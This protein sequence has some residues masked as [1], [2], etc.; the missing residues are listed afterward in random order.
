MLATAKTFALIGIDAHDVRV[1]VD[2]SNGGL[3]A[4]SLVGL[5]DAAVRES[6]ERVRSALINS[7]FKFPN[8]RITAN[9]AP[10]N[11]RKA[12]PGYDLAIA[13]ALLGGSG[14]LPD[15]ATDALRRTALAGELALNGRVRR[16]PGVLPMAERARVQGMERLVVPAEVAGEAALANLGLHRVKGES[17]RPPLRI[18]PVEHLDQLRTLGT[19][20]EP[21]PA[22]APSL[23]ELST[24]ANGFADLSELQGQSALRRALEIAAAGGHSLAV[25]GPPGAGKTM[26]AIRLPSI[27]PPLSPRES[28]EAMRVQ[29]AAGHEPTLSQA[30]RRP[31]RSPHHTIS[32]VGLVGGGNPP[33]PGEVTLAHRG[34]LFLDEFGEFSRSAL[35]ALRQPLEDG[36]VTIVRAGYAIELPCRFMLVAAAN[37]CPCGVGIESNRCKCSPLQARRYRAR[38]SGALADRVDI[39]VRIEQPDH[40]EL[41]SRQ[42][43]V[44]SA[45]V[46]ERVNGARERQAAR[47]G[48]GRTNAEMTPSET[49][50]HARLEPE[51][52][53]ALAEH[54]ATARLSGRGHERVLRLARTIADLDGRE[55]I[56][57][58]DVAEACTHRQR[59]DGDV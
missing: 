22:P 11:L 35:E 29:S 6:R 27:L 45:V 48:D 50:A 25:E 13:A 3:P 7:G 54:R 26:A 43:G 20:E 36:V 16:I 30:R 52:E 57:S 10:A 39:S 55:Q 31:F 51:A 4:F 12:G 33:R 32:T 53:A 42:P 28:V 58:D 23:P 8:D 17:A 9:L 47:L 49:R 40:A 41:G 56:S 19:E 38:L 46:L 59:Q 2:V 14:Q 5:P 1:E 44:A 21:P 37:P 18:V 34:V 15:Q 24:G